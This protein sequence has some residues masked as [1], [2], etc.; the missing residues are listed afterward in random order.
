VKG[1]EA[2]CKEGVKAR[3]NWRVIYG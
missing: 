2:Q 3:R 1:S